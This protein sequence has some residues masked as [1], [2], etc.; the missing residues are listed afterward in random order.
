MFIELERRVFHAKSGRYKATFIGIIAF[1]PFSTVGKRK[2]DKFQ[3]IFFPDGENVNF[4]S[5]THRMDSE[6]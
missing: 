1:D 5:N 2:F 3:V 4:D 6:A